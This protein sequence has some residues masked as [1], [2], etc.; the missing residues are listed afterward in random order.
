MNAFLKSRIAPVNLL[1]VTVTVLALWAVL[2][3][4]RYTLTVHRAAVQ[5]NDQSTALLWLLGG[6]A[7]LLTPAFGRRVRTTAAWCIGAAG[8]GAAMVVLSGQLSAALIALWLTALAGAWGD[9]LL[10]RLRISLPDDELRWCSI[11][12]PVGLTML[13]MLGLLLALAGQLAPLRVR[14]I[15]SVLTLLQW[16]TFQR[17]AV[18]TVRILKTIPSWFQSSPTYEQAMFTVSFSCL[19]VLGLMWALTPEIQYDGV[20]YHLAVPKVYVAEQRLVDIPLY[21]H[22]YLARLA[23]MLFTVAL[24]VHG[25]MAAKLLVFG[26]GICTALT[27]YVLGRSVFN[28]RS[29]RWAAL[30]FASTPLVIWLSTTTY[31]DL[32]LGLFFLCSLNCF[33]LWRESGQTGWLAASAIAAGAAIGAKFSILYGFPVVA[34]VLLY[35]LVRDRQLSGTGKTGRLAAY[36]ALVGLIAAPWYIITWVFTGNPFFPFLNGIFRN[37]LIPPVN[38]LGLSELWGV[39]TS[40]GAL[41]RLPFAFTFDTHLFGEALPDGAIGIALVLTPLAVLLAKRRTPAINLLMGAA[42]VYLLLLGLTFQYARFY[43]PVYPL[44]CLLVAGAIFGVESCNRRQG[45]I[46]GVLAIAAVIQS[47]ATPSMYWNIPGRFPLKLVLGRERPEAFLVQTLAPYRAVQYLNGV[48]QPGQ[49][50]LGLGVEQ[51]RFYLNAPLGSPGVSPEV[52]TILRTESDEDL[53]ERLLRRNY[54]YLCI[55]KLALSDPSTW[56]FL[57]ETFLDRHAVLEFERNHTSVYR[58]YRANEKPE[59]VAEP[60]NKAD[61]SA[62]QNPLKVCDGTGLGVT[63]LRW[64]APGA[65][66][67]EV[68]INDPDGPTFA[69]GEAEGSAETQKWVSDG[70]VFF[71]QDVSGGVKASPDNTIAVLKI[72]VTSAG[73][74]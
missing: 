19:C 28:A 70:T 20:N 46:A 2:M 69:A 62:S 45:L 7:V 73:C 51:A 8:I 74:P 29:G 61:F 39:G 21:I 60:P 59:P 32:C 53:I 4:A 33:L 38:D 49:K 16:R 40:P 54:V 52:T 43:I 18:R 71:L 56:P 17:C 72:K 34:L 58:L 5:S 35:D 41:L 31:I 64:K 48:T 10:R 15:L 67:I 26:M 68:H 12:L 65:S 42:G 55:N 63:T 11:I 37:P 57:D 22:S 13:G 66:R 3:L 9:W 36:I 1:W 27:V 24:A 6:I 25:Q 47:A 14:V 23:D 30:L 44:I 50:V